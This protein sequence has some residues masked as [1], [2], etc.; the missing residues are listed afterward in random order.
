MGMSATTMTLGL[1][2]ETLRRQVP[3]L[4]LAPLVP[5]GPLSKQNSLATPGATILVPWTRRCT[6]R[7][8]RLLK[9]AHSPLPLFNMG[10]TTIRSLD[11]WKLLTNLDMTRTRWGDFKQF[12]QT[13]LNRMLSRPYLST[14]PGT[15]LARLKKEKRGHRARSDNMVAGRG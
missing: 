9:P 13:V 4:L 15:L 14:T 8:T 10:L 12:A 1:R 6:L 5:Q 3:S 11:R 2:L 7:T